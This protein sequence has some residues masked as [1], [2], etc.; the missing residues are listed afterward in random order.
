MG[1]SVYFSINQLNFV[2]KN[3]F[4]INFQSHL[5]TCFALDRFILGSQRYNTLMCIRTFTKLIN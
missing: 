5:H 3:A 2:L 1:A 4:H